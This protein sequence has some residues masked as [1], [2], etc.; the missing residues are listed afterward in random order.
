VIVSFHRSVAVYS[1]RS[2]RFAVTNHVA[3]DVSRD[4][5]SKKKLL[6]VAL[7]FFAVVFSF[8]SVDTAAYSQLRLLKC[9]Q[10]AIY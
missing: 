2:G 1:C 5:Q 10:S 3:P 4:I 6:T 8:V 9:H 7:Y